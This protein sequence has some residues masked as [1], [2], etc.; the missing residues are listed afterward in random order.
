[1]SN[2]RPA[3]VELSAELAKSNPV[4]SLVKRW[5]TPLR[6]AVIASVKWTGEKMDTGLD[7]GVKAAATTTVAG[8]AAHYCDPLRHAFEAVVSWLEIAAKTLF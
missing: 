2:C 6:N 4:I 8:I 5:A 7:A 1:V 3:I